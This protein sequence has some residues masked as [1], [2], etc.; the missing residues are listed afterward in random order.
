MSYVPERT[1]MGCNKKTKKYDLIR[2]VKKN[3]D[4]FID[5]NGKMDG[6]G[7]YICNDVACLDKVVKSKRLERCLKIKID[8]DIYNKIRGVLI[9]E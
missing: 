7:A 8:D 2:I 1:C 9:G 3:N 5:K 4:V 6:R